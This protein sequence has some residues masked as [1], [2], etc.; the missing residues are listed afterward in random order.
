IV[1][2]KIRERIEQV[3]VTMKMTADVIQKNISI[4]VSEFP[5]DTKNFWESLKFSDVALYKAKET[6]RNKVVRFTPEMWTAG[7]Y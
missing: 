2:E 6:G 1:A 7:K 4:G 5:V 3:K